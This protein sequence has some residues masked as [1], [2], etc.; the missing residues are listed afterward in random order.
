MRALTSEE[1]STTV[2]M[3]TPSMLIRGDLIVRENVRVSI[4]LR[5]QG[6]PNFIHL[7]DAHVIQLAGSPPRTYTKEEL[8]V[9]TQELLGFHLAPP[10]HDPVDYESSEANRKMEPVHILMGS[11]ELRA[12]MRISTAAEF[13]T[14]LDVMTSNWLSLY[15]TEITNPYIPQFKIHVPM[16][17]VRPGKV[18]FGL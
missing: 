5:T 17:L 14:S 18:E 6:V 8:F 11:F 1:K 7:Y 12:M 2:M 9:P 3:Y 16:L 15:D 10:A 4:W 13:A